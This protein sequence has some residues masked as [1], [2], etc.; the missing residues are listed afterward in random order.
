MTCNVQ[1]DASDICD[2]CVFADVWRGIVD[3]DIVSILSMTH[4]PGPSKFVAR[5]IRLSAGPHKCK[6]PFWNLKM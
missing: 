3:A 5:C 6:E 1:C 2:I 4:N